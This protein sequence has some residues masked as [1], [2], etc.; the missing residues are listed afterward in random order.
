MPIATVPGEA[1]C[2][3]AEDSSDLSGAQPGDELLKARASHRSACGAA[4]IV[5]D[6]FDV[7][8]TPPPGFI[9]ELILAT[10]ALEVEL[11]LRLRRLANVDDGL[12]LEDRGRQQ[13]NACHR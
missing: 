5:V 7:P 6:H 12:P 3:E 1:G 11:N 4:Q 10:L 13:I 2:V 8:K 9:D